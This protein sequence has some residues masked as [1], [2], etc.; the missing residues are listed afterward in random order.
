MVTIPILQ[1]I[2]IIFAVSVAALLVC[3]RLKLPAIVGF[4]LTGIAIGPYG[5]ALIQSPHEV[6]V[7]AEIGVVLLLFTIG[8]E[9]SIKDLLQSKRAVLLGGAMQVC[10]TIA[11][12]MLLTREFCFALNKAVFAGFLVAL[13]STA[14]VLRTMQERGELDGAHGRMIL[15]ILIFQDIIIAP[16]MIFTPFLAGGSG[17]VT[18]SLLVLVG[19]GL[20]VVVMVIVLARYVV[21]TVLHLVARTQSR[22]LFLLCTVLICIAVAWLTSQL[23]LS[24]GLGAFLAGLVISESEF[25]FQALEGILPFKAVFTSFFFVSV[26][27]LLDTSLF[28]AQPGVV[29]GLALAV[30]VVK[31]VLAG[32]VALTLGMSARSAILV[33]LALSQVGEF[34]FILSKVGVS[35]GLL[36]QG[37]YALFLAVSI[38]TMIVTPFVIAMAPKIA[39]AAS[40]WPGLRHFRRGSYQRLANGNTGAKSLR[41]HLVI[42]GFGI[43]GRNLARAA[44]S[45]HIPYVIIEMNPDTV[46]TMRREGE[47]IMYG[48]AT[49]RAMLTHAVVKRARIVVLT[50]ADPM[51]ARRIIHA[52]RDINPGTH[53]IVRTRFVKETP[54]LLRLGASDVI[55]EEFETSVEIFTRV[56]MKYLVPRDDIDRF[57]ADIRSHG[58]AMLRSLS[59]QA[60]T[61]GDLSLHIPEIEIQAIRLS[62][63]S[64]V[65][66]K[67]LASADLRRLFGVTVLALTR[68][69]ELITN[70]DG[71][72]RL[73]SGDMLYV[74]GSA[75][76]CMQA[77]RAVTEE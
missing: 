71:D 33:G 56:L 23:G 59:R 37:M 14:I 69:T 21:P 6:E 27:M 50:I 9:F 58:Y 3:H 11:V 65:S 29:F 41:D 35:H 48:D 68:G 66:G 13:S 15:S 16:M 1:D 39:D 12:T 26:G 34:S 60:A 55:P 28:S 5:L 31:T 32:G 77:G 53:I 44:R 25:S 42:I 63:A 8:I 70:P 40:A 30:L 2:A 22:E 49:S 62:E 67:T 18:T 24:L 75:E 10:L 43:N 64:P 38:T 72:Q 45:A 17:D 54:E 47:P 19:K 7:L 74:I 61:I 20:A 4:L 51:G 76:R 52:I 57:T 36:D 46:R 73:E